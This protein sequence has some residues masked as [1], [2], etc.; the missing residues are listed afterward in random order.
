MKGESM[1]G[2]KQDWKVSDKQMDRILNA[3][4]GPKRLPRNIFPKRFVGSV[5]WVET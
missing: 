1:K 2:D 3:S 5:Q 4:A